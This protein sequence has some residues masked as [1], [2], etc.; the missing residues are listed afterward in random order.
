MTK[1]LSLLL[2]VLGCLSLHA[3]EPRSPVNQVFQFAFS[4]TRQYE[5]VG[6]VK[7]S[8][9][10][11]WIPENCEKLRGLILMGNNVP[12]HMLAG[13]E[14]IRAACRDNA[15]GLVWAVPTFWHFPKEMKGREAEQADFLQSLLD[16]L[17]EKSG[18]AEVATVPWLPIGESG[19]L[20]MVCGLID[21]RPEHCIAGIC[22]K[23][24]HHPK[25]RTVPLLWTLGTAQ[26][27]GQKDSDIRTGWNSAG[28]SFVNW[29]RDRAQSD[30][31]L[32]ILIE[33]SSGHFACTDEMVEYFREY[34]TAACQARLA[35][36]GTLKPVDLASGFLANLPVPGVTDLTIRPAA[37]ATDRSGA[38]FFTE[39]LARAAQKIATT[40]WQAETQLVGLTAG[41]NCEV[42]PFSF[43]SVTE[44]VVTTDGPFS[45]TGAPLETIPEGFKGAGEKLATTPGKAEVSW[46]CGPYAPDGKGGFRVALDRTWKAAASY[47]IAR[48]PGTDTVRPSYQPAAVKLQENKEGAPQK[49]TFSPPEKLAAN[50]P[51]VPLTAESD[52]GLPVSF[53][54]LS[55]PAVIENNRLVLTTIPPRS[56]YP[57]EVMVGAWQWG[58]PTEPKVQTAAMERRTILL[59]KP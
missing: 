24:P 40:N 53:C 22:V 18:Y 36:D 14:A 21:S 16:G 12:E 29:C 43:N 23:N 48:Q 6:A 10:Y 8:T 59:E 13:H 54:V 2:A 34:I 37:D 35:P 55:G 26:E 9:V 3:D 52:A 38:W 58:R 45:V 31:P 7:T 1:S 17:A 39:S 56:R 49:I 50:S 42:R 51:P 30:W 15:L 19:H 46:I 33:P 20:L 44:I 5:G 57:V 4:G 27:W 47:L 32:S 41:T 28:G 25:N 11:L